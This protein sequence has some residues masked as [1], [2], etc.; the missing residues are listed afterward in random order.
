MATLEII[1]SPETTLRQVSAPVRSFDQTLKHFALELIET[2]QSAGGIGLSAPQC[3]QLRRMMVV[4]TNN[5]STL[6]LDDIFVNPKIKQQSK[7]GF[8]N[9]SCLSVP[10]ISGNVFR[11]TKIQIDAQTI[12]GEPITRELT[13]M[14]AVCFQHELDH[15]NGILF[16]DRLPWFER[17]R[18]RGPL[19]RLNKTQPPRPLSYQTNV[20]K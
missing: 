9:E 15:L 7:I 19:R 5:T 13:G 3:S 6:T 2:L 20:N 11:A 17:L 12:S 14:S 1:R 10:D 8:V 18:L 16:I 4:N